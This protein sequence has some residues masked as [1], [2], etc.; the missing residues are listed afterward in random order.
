M[1]AQGT[2]MSPHQRASLDMPKKADVRMLVAAVR[3]GWDVPVAVRV[4]AARRL[5][6]I[7]EDPRCP[8][9]EKVRAATAVVVL[10]GDNQNENARG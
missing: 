6:A 5:M 1:Q 8:D 4:R 3:R 9:A 7:V 10:N 2:T